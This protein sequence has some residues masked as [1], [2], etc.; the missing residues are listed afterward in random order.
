MTVE[1]P[2]RKVLQIQ[3]DSNNILTNKNISVREVSRLLGKYVAAA[4]AVPYAIIH[5]RALERDKNRA[6]KNHCGGFD[7]PMTLSVEAK[8]DVTWWIINIVGSHVRILPLPIHRTI[9]S[10]ASK[11][12]W[13]ATCDGTSTNG[14]WLAQEWLTYDINVL[15]LMAAK[16]ALLSFLSA[17]PEGSNS[18]YKGGCLFYYMDRLVYVLFSSF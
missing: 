11:W 7:K 6:L 1:L 5:Y 17:E 12:G 14:Q 18:G 15:E 2:L 10:D 8:G 3:D 16:W 4:E 9:Y 13:G